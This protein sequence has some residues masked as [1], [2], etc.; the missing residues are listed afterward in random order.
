[1]RAIATDGEAR[2]VIDRANRQQ[3]SIVGA[4]TVAVGDRE[5]DRR[6]PRQ[7][8]CGR[9]GDITRGTA[10]AKHDVGIRHQGGIARTATHD[11][12]T[13]R[14]FSV[15]DSHCQRTGVAVFIDHLVTDIAD[16][17]RR[18]DARTLDVEVE[19]VLVTV[20]VDKAQRRLAKTDGTWIK[21]HLERRAANDR[22][23]RLQADGEVRRVCATHRDTAQGETGRAAIGN[24]E[25]THQRGV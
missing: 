11:Q 16:R 1:M 23:C 21:G 12:R 24:R 9:D 5:C 3:E 20:I 7:S 25:G 14:G 19:R 10:A 6:R 17:R 22:R 2:R 13:R 4:A 8:R 15:T 18:V